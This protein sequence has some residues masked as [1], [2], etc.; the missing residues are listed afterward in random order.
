MPSR[1]VVL[2]CLSVFAQPALAAPSCATMIA[3]VR[4]WLDAHPH[5][6][7]TRAQTVEAQLQHQPTAASVAKAKMESRDHIVEQLGEAERQR[8][9]GD[10]AGCEATLGDIARM[11]RP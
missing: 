5:V 2:I 9:S 6:S 11:L 7:G 3:E 4:A 10:G 8:R 1:L